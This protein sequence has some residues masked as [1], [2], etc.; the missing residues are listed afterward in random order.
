MILAVLMG[1]LTLGALAV[2]PRL[3]TQYSLK[4]F[5]PLNN[6]LLQQE[7]KSRETFQL[8]ELQPFIVIAKLDKTSTWFDKSKLKALEKI[9][10]SLGLLP[11]VTETLSLATIQ[12]V[13][14]NTT[15]LS[16]GP[17]L[18]Y[19]PEDRWK[20][21]IPNNPL[22]A[23]QLISK[24]G[25]IASIVVQIK[26][27]TT[28][29]LEFLRQELTTK[30]KIALPFAEI[31]LGGTPAVQAD[32]NI[33][34][35]SE[36][37]NFIILG[38]LA[39]FITLGFVFSNS[40]P[41]I[42]SFV[43]VVCTNI[44]VLATMAMAGYSLSILSSTIPILTTV[45]VMSLCL[46]TLLRY[47]EEQKTDPR[48]SHEMLVLKTLK[49]IIKP[50]LI[51]SLT[52][53]IGFLTLL[54]TDVPIIKDYGWTAAFSIIIGW[55]ATTILL[56]PLM[57]LLPAARARHWAWSKARWGL[58]LL[59]HSK[60]WL[61]LIV[62][63]SVTL[64]Y[65]GQHLSW[66]A[67]LFDDLPENHQARISTELIDK[68][69]GGMIPIDMNLE[70]SQDFWNHPQAILNLNLLIQ[71]LRQTKSVGSVVGLPELIMAIQ[72]KQAQNIFLD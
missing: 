8:T 39:C 45:D 31:T 26:S 42:I 65:Q 34:L 23:P 53:M 44:L 9:T 61:F 48:L 38:L 19:T 52:T 40:S 33:L 62:F 43:I 56:Y 70:G 46:H 37:R 57:M 13:Q 29:E 18:E 64:G 54:F 14:N 10:M 67:R 12:A 60:I 49:A 32:I 25:T 6:P 28:S 59:K 47:T 4:Q 41:L 35:E 16:I 17:L 69:L 11:G 22:I 72:D 21:D 27:A 63:F 66:S 1:A 51:A 7:E 55:V 50:N 20:L 71:E 24:D 3:H 36:I 30:T 5:L 58:H 2:L 68:K 15:G